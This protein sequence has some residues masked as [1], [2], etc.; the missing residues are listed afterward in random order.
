MQKKN[1]PSLWAITTKRVGCP[2]H[3]A[4]DLA[5]SKEVLRTTVCEIKVGL[6]EDDRFE[7]KSRAVEAMT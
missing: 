5:L 4:V 1:T 2:E 7:T 6:M 3:L